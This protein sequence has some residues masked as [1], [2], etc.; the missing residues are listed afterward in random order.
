M[1]EQDFNDLLQEI[2]TMS[3]EEYLELKKKLNNYPNIQ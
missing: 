3:S 1:N 2:E